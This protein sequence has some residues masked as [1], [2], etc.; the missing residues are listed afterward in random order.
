VGVK[1]SYKHVS[2][3]WIA[4]E[5]LLF[6]SPDQTTL[7]FCSCGWIKSEVYRRHV[8]KAEE[9]LARILDAAAWI[10]KR[11]DQPR[12]TICDLHTWVTKYI[13]VGGGIWEHLLWT[14]TSGSLLCNK[15]HLK[16]KLKL[17]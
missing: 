11:A 16:S 15:C 3:S 10:K 2:D 7:D 17:Q 13:E 5:I 4:T 1:N 12:W 8:E 14:V 6:E 9:L